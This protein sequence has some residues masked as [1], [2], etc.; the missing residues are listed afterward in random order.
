MY[1]S[2]KHRHNKY[3]VKQ[4]KLKAICNQVYGAPCA[5]VPKRVTKLILV[6]IMPNV[7]ESIS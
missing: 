1:S 2:R 4:S 3:L 7:V 6:D 5:L